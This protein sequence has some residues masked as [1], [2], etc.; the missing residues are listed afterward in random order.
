MPRPGNGS[1]RSVPS[2]KVPA[3]TKAPE[4]PLCPARGPRERIVGLASSRATLHPDEALQ[5][6]GDTSIRGHQVSCLLPFSLQLHPLLS[7]SEHRLLFPVYLNHLTLPCPRCALLNVFT[8]LSPIGHLLPLPYEALHGCTFLILQPCSPCKEFPF[9]CTVENSL[10]WVEL[11]I[12][13]VNVAN[14]YIRL[15]QTYGILKTEKN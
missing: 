9:L 11:E 1:P 8:I 10:T 13:E 4:T 2:P 15:L 3:A 7:P 5:G 14:T 6:F 12:S